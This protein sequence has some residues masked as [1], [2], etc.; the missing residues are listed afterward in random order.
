MQREAFA[1]VSTVDVTRTTVPFKSFGLTAEYHIV[2][3]DVGLLE[4]EGLDVGVPV[5]STI[6]LPEVAVQ[7]LSAP[8]L[9]S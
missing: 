8:P 3:K 4:M 6:K 7:L 5:T 2:G 9:M 1:G